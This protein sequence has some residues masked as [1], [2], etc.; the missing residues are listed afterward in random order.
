MGCRNP[1]PANKGLATSKVAPPKC[2]AERRPA[3]AGSLSLV[4]RKGVTKSPRLF[5]E[6]ENT[7]LAGKTDFLYLPI[8]PDQNGVIGGLGAAVFPP[9]FRFGNN[10]LTSL[11]GGFVS[12]DLQAVLSGSQF[13]FA[14]FRGLRKID[15]LGKGLRKSRYCQCDGG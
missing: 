3:T 13:G 14:E 1:L 9:S 8:F 4:H 7:F 5:A 12:I 2:Q 10:L 11:H 15:G 6:D